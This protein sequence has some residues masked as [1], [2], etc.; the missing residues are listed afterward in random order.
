MNEQMT[1]QMENK[2]QAYPEPNLVDSLCTISVQ[3]NQSLYQ[4]DFNIASDF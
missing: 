1:Q 3:L 2:E 4:M